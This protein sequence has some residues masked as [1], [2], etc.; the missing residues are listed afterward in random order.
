MS[1][2]KPNI[3]KSKNDKRDAYTYSLPNKLRVFIIHDADADTACVAMLVKI[4]YFQDTVP[5][6]AH[7]LEHMLFNGT[8]KYP[9]EK[10]FS[11][12]ISQNNGMQNAYTSHDHTCYFFTIA[13]EGLNQGLEM[14]GDFFVS[15]LLNKDCVDREKEAVDSEHK[16][17]IN[18]DNWRRQELLRAASNDE[19][20][21]SKFGT[22][23]NETLAIHDIDI[24]VREFFEKYYSSD[25]MT[26]VILTKEKIET[27]KNIVDNI[28]S[29]ITIKKINK[30]D[31]ILDTKILKSPKIIKYLPIED[32][33][34]LILIWEIPFF[35]DTP[36][37]SPLEFLYRL[38]GNE[39]QNSIHD[40]LTDK[41]YIID[42]SCYIRDI[43]FNKCFFCIDIKMTPLGEK[44]KKTIVG[45][46]ME[47]IKLLSKNIDSD[48]LK[49]LYNEQLELIKYK[50]DNFEKSDCM[51]TVL[52]LC[53][54][55]NSYNIPPE[56]V[57]VIDS[58]QEKYSK[59]IKQNLEKI[60]NEMTLENLIVVVG[61]KKYGEEKY[62]NKTQIF[63]HYGT[64]YLTKDKVYSY[65]IKDK[66]LAL[67]P[68]TNKFIST[69]DKK[70]DL[71]N[72]DPVLLENNGIMLYWMPNVKYNVPDICLHACINLQ[73]ALHDVYTDTCISLYL[74]ALSKEINHITY[75]SHSALYNFNLV[76]VFGKIYIKLRGNHE[77]FTDVLKSFFECLCNYKLITQKG[78]ESAKFSQIK[79]DK[80]Y[81]YVS[82]RNKVTD[83]F[84]KKI[85][86][87]YYD[88]DDRLKIINKI[89]KKDIIEVFKKIIPHNDII[90]FIA[91]NC[92]K[93]KALEISEIFKLLPQKKHDYSKYKD[94]LYQNIEKR[95]DIIIKNDNK[96]EENN[97]NGYYIFI[98]ELNFTQNTQWIKPFC[99]L[100]ILDNVISTEYFDEL[101]TK[102]M[103]GYVVAGK[104]YNIGEP[105][106][107]QYYYLF[108]VQSPNKTTEEITKRTEKFIIDFTKKLEKL[109][110]EELEVIKN[111]FISGILTEFNNLS[112]MASF[113]FYNEIEN[114]YLKYNFREVVAEYC[115]KIKL[116][117]L[118]E[119]YREKFV[120]NKKIVN[121]Q[122][123]KEKN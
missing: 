118:I 80:N 103:Y 97:A 24:K 71:K 79:E 123:K 5:G 28:F 78:F 70:H 6:I 100:K 12:Y 53:S 39:Q 69:C 29:E 44:N 13:Q 119:F 35:K 19:H 58:M 15:P 10:M 26:L 120:N 20:W 23:S 9:D 30:K 51:D 55:I 96:I 121:V 17:N 31:L 110:K 3:L 105:Y 38:I 95:E 65:E 81:L 14:F 73:I 74:S 82:P 42:F 113:Y 98:D 61:S 90:L 104:I 60:L 11:S 99:L 21:F 62:K 94:R 102:E 87:G 50:F 107:S 2:I 84:N 22:G 108:L 34:R 117:D 43:I 89:E 93:E 27:I 75:M 115:K 56:H 46:I 49:E 91:G 77:K 106:S 4:G 7:F 72:S 52:N 88:S 101:R 83:V 54:L 111:S 45:V 25:L 47:Y 8:E 86:N 92:T 16:K 33:D 122:I 18:D 41:E 36:T 116:D 59:K 32:D 68:K 40:I 37:Q 67:L 48:I 114:K 57:F 76:Y 1:K 63:P 109:S 64:E 112:E 85:C 66:D